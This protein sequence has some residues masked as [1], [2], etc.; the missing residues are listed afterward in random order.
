MEGVVFLN[1]RFLPLKEARVS[2]LSPGF[3]YAWGLFETMRSVNGK[4]VYCNEHLRRIKNSCAHLR[5]RFPYS[6]PGL[7]RHIEQVV[8]INGSSDAYV[9]LT[10]W[11][12]QN[13][14][15][16][17]LIF[18]RKYSPLA[19]VEYR[20]GFS[21]LFSKARI[22]EKCFLPRLKSTNYLL[23][24]LAY[25]EAKEKG[26]DEAIILNSRG[27]LVE[28]SRSNVFFIKEN[29]IFTPALGCGC[30]SGITRK[31]VFDL[32]K[33]KGIKICEGKF[34]PSD[35]F[36][37]DEAFL[38]NS[39]MGIMPLASVEKRNTGKGPLRATRVLM[40]CYFKLLTDGIK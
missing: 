12:N 24:Q 16:D 37:A 21:C 18:V 20:K 14:S 19:A 25:V 4:I 34:V 13:N 29:K 31:V 35:L 17:T 8:K 38:T 33:R 11:K 23:Y 28:G 2:V 3:L 10:L 32:A 1:G 9:R 40:K 26:F 30:L 22:N 15:A 27:Y 36:S 7:K 5:M 6:L 39:L